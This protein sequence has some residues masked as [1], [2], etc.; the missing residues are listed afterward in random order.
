MNPGE[1][2]LVQEFLPG[3][4][5]SL[6]IIGNVDTGLEVLPV[7]EVDYQNLPSGPRFQCY[8]SKWDPSFWT[9]IGLRAAV[10]EDRQLR[11]MQSASIDLFACPRL[12]RLRP[13]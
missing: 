13:F 7:I 2:C 12:S 8:A 3:A 6:G 4:E 9:N 5:F 1:P 11:E 10:L